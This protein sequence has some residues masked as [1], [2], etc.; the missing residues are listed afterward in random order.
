MALEEGTLRHIPDDEAVGPRV[1]GDRAPGAQE[2]GQQRGEGCPRPSR[3]PQAPTTTPRT[4]NAR[5]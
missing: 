3:T 1:H 5:I 2:R 4:H